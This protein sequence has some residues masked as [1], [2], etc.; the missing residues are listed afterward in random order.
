MRKRVKYRGFAFGGNSSLSQILCVLAVGVEYF[1]RAFFF[2]YDGY[3]IG[4]FFRLPYSKGVC[5]SMNELRGK[6]YLNGGE[7]GAFTNTNN[8]Q[9][10][11]KYK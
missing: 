2:V 4:F 8:V 1:K 11:I 3:K 10:K 9:V 5:E 7:G 6:I